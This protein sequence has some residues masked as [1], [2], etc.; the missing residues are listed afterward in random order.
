MRARKHVRPRTTTR[1]PS[2]HLLHGSRVSHYASLAFPT[3][4]R[5]V[6]V[7][8]IKTINPVVLRWH[9]PFRTSSADT[10]EFPLSKLLA[11][12]LSQYEIAIL[13]SEQTVRYRCLDQARYLMVYQPSTHQVPDVTPTPNRMQESQLVCL[14]VGYLGNGEG[15][16][17]PLTS[18]VAQNTGRVLLGVRI[19]DTKASDCP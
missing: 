3:R 6:H 18:W 10:D 11:S 14:H 15:Q 12:L 4:S 16:S 17:C 13:P 9:N 19:M 7:R 1:R 8:G 5:Q 2:Q